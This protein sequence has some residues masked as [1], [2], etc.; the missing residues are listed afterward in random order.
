MKQYADY[1]NFAWLYNREWRAYGENIFP[2]LK[3]IAG[4]KLPDKANILDLCCGT[5]QLA[6]VLIEKGYRVTGIDGSAEMLRYAK[7]NAP[8]AEFIPKDAR[9]FK[10]PPEYNAVFSTFDALNHVMNIDELL[11]V[12]INVK[13]CLVNGGIFI[14]DMTTKYHF[15]VNMKTYNVVREIPEYLYTLQGSYNEENKTGEFHC[16]VFQPEGNLWKRSDVFLHQTWYPCEAVKSALTQ[17]GFTCIR[18]HSFNQQ[19]E[20]IEGTDVMDRIFFY[21]QKP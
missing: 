19:R 4:N 16:T 15:E 21:A 13:R 20:L 9:T 2:A 10:L 1:D 6:K 11:E 12:L 5:G 8:A 18:A 17:A 14:F 7:E 3:S